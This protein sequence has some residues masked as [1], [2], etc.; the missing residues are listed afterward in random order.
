MPKEQTSVGE[1]GTIAFD[2]HNARAKGI[3]KETFLKAEDF[4]SRLREEFDKL[5]PHRTE[6]S[7]ITAR[8]F[9]GNALTTEQM[10]TELERLDSPFDI[11]LSVDAVI[12]LPPNELE[13]SALVYFGGNS[14]ERTRSSD[15]IRENQ[16]ILEHARSLSQTAPEPLPDK[17]TSHLSING[18]GLNQQ[19][20]ERVFSIYSSVFTDYVT[21]L[22][23][24][25]VEMMIKQ[26]IVGLVRNPQGEIVSLTVAEIVPKVIDAIT[27]VELTD[28]VTDPTLHELD[29]KANNINHWARDVLLD[30]IK[31]SSSGITVVYS[32]ARADL[33][34]VL[35]NNFWSGFKVGGILP[36]SC[37]MKTKVSSSKLERGNYTDLVVMYSVL[38]KN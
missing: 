7:R 12:P 33:I 18:N 22:T 3:L 30:Y 11:P 23:P 36:N 27:L 13:L 10:Q 31:E 2:R 6:I 9:I 29:P 20:Y 26:N 8:A 37:H 34:S 35:R 24:E 32:E 5:T 1:I 19:D 14:P 25:S 15:V 38:E 4:I 17:Y 28:S 21:E 16:E